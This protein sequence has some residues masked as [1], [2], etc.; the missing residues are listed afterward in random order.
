MRFF[1]K[2]DNWAECV[3]GEMI[4]IETGKHYFTNGK[5]IPA[6]IKDGKPEPRPAY[7]I[8][9]RS[10]R[11]ITVK[12]AAE[13]LIYVPV[14]VRFNEVEEA[15]LPKLKEMY[16]LAGYANENAALLERRPIHTASGHFTSVTAMAAPKDEIDLEI[17]SM[18][19]CGGSAGRITSHTKA[20]FT[21]Y[22]I[23]GIKAF[24]NLVLD[25]TQA[26]KIPVYLQL[27]GIFYDRENMTR[28]THDQRYDSNV[29]L[30]DLRWTTNLIPQC[31]YGDINEVMKSIT[32]LKQEDREEA[33]DARKKKPAALG[34]AKPAPKP[35]AKAQK[36]SYNLIGTAFRREYDNYHDHPGYFP[37]FNRDDAAIKLCIVRGPFFEVARWLGYR[38]MFGPMVPIDTLFGLTI[39]EVE[40]KQIKWPKTLSGPLTSLPAAIAENADFALLKPQDFCQRCRTPIYDRG[41]AVFD[42]HETTT[43]I[44]YCVTCMH[45]RYNEQ[46]LVDPKGS[47][48]CK[49]KVLAHY[50]T[51]L[52]LERIL[53]FLPNQDPT[54]RAI[55]TES[56]DAYKHLANDNDKKGEIVLMSK[57]FIG[58]VDTLQNY[59]Q[60]C[61]EWEKA[62]HVIPI[63]PVFMCSYVRIW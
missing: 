54:Y 6:T 27:L 57:S 45:L 29:T 39:Y 61:A 34:N 23:T 7:L 14:H 55:L 37:G 43:G 10:K 52:T 15:L 58:I 17:R 13:G 4:N 9:T 46:R 16:K 40:H 36:E 33:K 35:A 2:C 32:A 59:D 19:F 11:T 3:A 24:I 25:H 42:N 12:Y 44:P 1:K 62:G 53:N 60:M 18:T 31:T 48:L 56:Y 8:Y 30:K 5:L 22:Y 26:N 41:Y 63:K 50:K 21:W 49:D 28:F 38:D 51:P 20:I 47:L